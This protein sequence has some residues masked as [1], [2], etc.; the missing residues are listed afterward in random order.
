MNKKTEKEHLDH[1]AKELTLHVKSTTS[2][3]KIK[4]DIFSAIADDKIQ[5]EQINLI[6][7]RLHNNLST[8]SKD[9]LIDEIAKLTWGCEFLFDIAKAQEKKI[10]LNRKSAK[11]LALKESEY[12]EKVALNR[13]LGAKKANQRHETSWKVMA[14]N[15]WVELSDSLERSCGHVKLFNVLTKSHPDYEW[16]LETLKGWVK[17]WKR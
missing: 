11:E 13:K 7:Q 1:K 10:S 4:S 5:R 8:L 17:S 14:K 9:E 12:R 15:K 2:T 3:L 6:R 16:K